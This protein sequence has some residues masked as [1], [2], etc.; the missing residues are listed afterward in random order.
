MGTLFTEISVVGVL[1]P[2]RLLTRRP[3]PAVSRRAE[4][5]VDDRMPTKAKFLLTS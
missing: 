2:H 5:A 1:G 3:K 4:L